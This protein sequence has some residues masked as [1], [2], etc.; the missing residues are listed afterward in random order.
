MQRRILIIDDHDDLA[1]ALE[2]VFTAVGHPVVILENR[3]DG[4][5]ATNSEQFD[6]VISDL[7]IQTPRQDSLNGSTESDDA[8]H[9]KAF[10]V[11]AN[12]RRD[13]FDEDELKNV[14]AT[15]LDYKIRYR[16]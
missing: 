2:E 9:I 5:E 8:Q 13:E 1:T 3:A 11:S 15:V 6:L 7:D 4:L 10:K 12:F 14:V 16:R